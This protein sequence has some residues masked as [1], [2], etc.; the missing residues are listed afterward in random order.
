MQCKIFPLHSFWIV[1]TL[2]GILGLYFTC[3]KTFDILLIWKERQRLSTE[4]CGGE[5]AQ[6]RLYGCCLIGFAIKVPVFPFHMASIS[7]R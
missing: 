7:L 2:I 3:G 6:P 4:F 1:L 5:R